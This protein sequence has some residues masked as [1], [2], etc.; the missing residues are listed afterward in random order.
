MG[1]MG[2]AQPLAAS[3]AGAVSICVEID[4][5]RIDKRIHDG[6]CDLKVDN[7]KEALQLVD[8]YKAEKKPFSIG[9]IGNT[10]EILP[11][12][13]KLGIIPDIVTDQ[14]SA[15][16]PLNGYYP[17]GYSKAE[18]DILRTNDPEKYLNETYKSIGLHVRSMLEFQKKGSI[19]FDYGNNIRGIAK[20]YDNVKNA[21]DFPGFV[22]AY[23]RP[24]FCDGK[25]P[26]R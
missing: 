17:A 8:K 19:V 3:F 11:E 18:A 16:D 26:F 2:G 15:H 13:L 22:P 5:T 25:G 6:Y 4:E 20:Y 10:A 9:L 14:T 7:L 12:L 21:F 1:G 24:L 23:I